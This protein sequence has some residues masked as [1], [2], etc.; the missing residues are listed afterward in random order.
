[1][2]HNSSHEIIVDVPK[3][4]LITLASNPWFVS[5]VIGHASILEAYDPQKNKFVSF[6]ELTSVPTRFKVAYIFNA[7]DGKVSAYLGEVEG[8]K[9]LVDTVTYTGFTYD[10]KMKWEMNFYFKEVAP[11]KTKLT[12]IYKID[13]EKGFFS[14]FIERS[15]VSLAEHT[16]KG[17]AIPFIQLYMSQLTQLK[18]ASHGPV[19]YRVV[20]EEEGVVGEVLAKLMRLVKEN[21]IMHAMIALE[22][23]GFRGKVDLR[24]GK[25]V[26]SWFKWPD[27]SIKTGNDAIVEALTSTDKGKGTLYTVDV[28]GLVDHVFDQIFS[29]LATKAAKKQA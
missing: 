24:N 8:P 5:G 14:R 9:M 23:E 19:D 2:M 25:P 11:G 21:N 20:A 15:H 26:K 1:M 6:D 12:I 4:V 22:G 27:G 28:E 7:P 29:E 16:I 10:N 3:S 17:H 13:E 18:V